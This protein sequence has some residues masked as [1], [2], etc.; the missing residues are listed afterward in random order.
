[1]QSEI[2]AGFD[3][4]AAIGQMV[5]ASFPGSRWNA[6]IENLLSKHR[7]GG[8]IFFSQN[9]GK[10]K[11]EV[12]KLTR[13]IARLGTDRSGGLPPFI[14]VDEEGGRVSRL[15]KLIGRYPSQRETGQKGGRGATAAIKEN[16]ES[17]AADVSSLGFNLTWAPVLDALTNPANRV[18]GDRAFGDDARA[19]ATCGR[20][21][22]RALREGGLFTCAKHFPGHGGTA[23]DSHKKLP[24]IETTLA[25]LKR[26]DILPFRA[27]V[28][29][30]V[31]FIMTAH[32]LFKRIDP[33]FPATF[34]KK[35]LTKIL[36]KEMGYTGLIVTDDLNMKAVSA[37][38]SVKKRIALAVNAGA[39]VLLIRDDY[40][41][42]ENFMESFKS[43]VLDGKIPLKRIKESSGR[44]KRIKRKYPG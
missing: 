20:A 22:I 13:K 36:R 33:D 9:V 26:S 35:F 40:S 32:I 37:G 4:D 25:K 28:S 29:Q 21:A 12:K 38:Y 5:I 27:A 7:I 8:V 34:S 11:A 14:S 44:V 30:R 19:V 24:L 39:D 6:R 41:G 1:M 31:D 17:L 43:L 3:L 18:I 42:I 23:E 16:Y 2:P 15:E 10:S